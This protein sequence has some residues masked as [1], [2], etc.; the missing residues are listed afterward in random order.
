MSRLLI[1][2]VNLNSD[3]KVR[4]IVLA[5]P[6]QGLSYVSDPSKNCTKLIPTMCYCIHYKLLIA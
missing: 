3:Y 6:N 5:L 2:T 4:G 1:T